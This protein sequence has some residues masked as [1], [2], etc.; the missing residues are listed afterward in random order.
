VRTARRFP[1]DLVRISVG[2][3]HPNDLLQDLEKAL[4]T[5]E[6]K[7]VCGALAVSLAEFVG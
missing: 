4:Q 2:I 3:E 6:T 7:T 1:D 5:A